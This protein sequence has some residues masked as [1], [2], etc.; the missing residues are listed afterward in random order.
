MTSDTSEST[1]VL[2]IAKKGA[3]ETPVPI[4]IDARKI[5]AQ[6]TRVAFKRSSR[7]KN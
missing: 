3:D 4:E 5:A 6:S 1:V 7:Q 2:P